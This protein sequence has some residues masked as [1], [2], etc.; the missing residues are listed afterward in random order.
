[1]TNYKKLKNGS[2]LFPLTEDDE[3]RIRQAIKKAK[4]FM[5]TYG[6]GRQPI[7]IHRENYL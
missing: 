5:A 2:R 4:C 3:Y 7:M 6:E 1:M